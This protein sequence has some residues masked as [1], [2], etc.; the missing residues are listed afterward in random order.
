VTKDERNIELVQRA[1]VQLKNLPPPFGVKDASAIKEYYKIFD[2]PARW[3]AGI[4]TP[5]EEIVPVRKTNRNLKP[6][7][8]GRSFAA[9]PLN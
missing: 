3:K 1:V 7:E 9:A 6:R 2:G 8:H 5:Q 4:R